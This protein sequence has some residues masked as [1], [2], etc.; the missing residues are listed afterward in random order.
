MPTNRTPLNR[1][2]RRGFS[3]EGLALAERYIELHRTGPIDEYHKV[4]DALE[5]ATG[6]S[7]L[8]YELDDELTEL[9]A[10]VAHAGGAAS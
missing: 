1:G 7:D 10:A 2:S 5:E 3:A 8:L 6:Y 4:S 9:K